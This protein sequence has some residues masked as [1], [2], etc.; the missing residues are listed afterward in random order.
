MNV[1]DLFAENRTLEPGQRK[2]KKQK[3]FYIQESVNLSVLKNKH[4]DAIISTSFFE[5]PLSCVERDKFGL[6]WLMMFFWLS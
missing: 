1:G 2:S 4:K 3:V 6:R 5:R